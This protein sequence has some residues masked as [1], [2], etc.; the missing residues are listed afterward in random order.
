MGWRGIGV[1]SFATRFVG[2]TEVLVARILVVTEGVLLFEAVEPDLV[3]WW[4]K[5]CGYMG[6]L[7]GGA[8]M[9][10]VMMPSSY[11]SDKCIPILKNE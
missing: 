2:W 4:C 3:A 5:G 7:M 1:F 6:M 8:A 10:I 9:P 11:L